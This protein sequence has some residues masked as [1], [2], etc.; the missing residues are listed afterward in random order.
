MDIVYREAD[1][2]WSS[3][4]RRW[5]MMRRWSRVVFRMPVFDIYRIWLVLLGSLHCLTRLRVFTLFHD[6]QQFLV[7]GLLPVFA[8]L[9]SWFYL[10]SYSKFLWIF[11]GLL[12][13][14]CC[15]IHLIFCEWCLFTMQLV[16]EQRLSVPRRLVFFSMSSHAL[17]L[18]SRKE[19]LTTSSI[20]PGA[21][22]KT[23]W[24]FNILGRFALRL[25]VF[26]YSFRLL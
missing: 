20:L 14:R 10:S 7:Y 6:S 21:Y 9:N 23:I 15:M 12:S 4:A 5:R 19:V 17:I 18:T 16:S 24:G 22:P 26:S 2:E 25:V 13:F 3:L 1:A 11:S 8:G